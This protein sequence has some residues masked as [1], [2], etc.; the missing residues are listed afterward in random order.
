MT[1][2]L[3][4]L[5]HSS[6]FRAD[7]LFFI[8][9]TTNYIRA[10]FWDVF[11]NGTSHRKRMYDFA[12]E[13]FGESQ[14]NSPLFYG[15]TRKST[16]RADNIDPLDQQFIDFIQNLPPDLRAP[17]Q[18][19][20][21]QEHALPY[22][23]QDI[24]NHLDNLR[25]KRNYLTHY[26]TQQNKPK[27]FHDEQV[28]RFMA[29][30]LHPELY[31]QWIGRIHSHSIKLPHPQR[32]T[33]HNTML[34]LRAIAKEATEKR[35]TTTQHLYSASRS[36]KHG[37]L[38]KK[39][40]KDKV[41]SIEKWRESYLKYY[42]A[43]ARDTAPKMHY[44]KTCYHFIGKENIMQL[45]AT[46]LNA[47]PLAIERSMDHPPTRDI[48]FKRDIECLFLLGARINMLLFRHLPLD[49]AKRMDDIKDAH[50]KEHLRPLTQRIE[51]IIRQQKTCRNT[52]KHEELEIQRQQL[53]A[54]K[55]RLKSITPPEIL[56]LQQLQRIRDVIAHNGSFWHMH[57]HEGQEISLY[58]IF[59]R[60]FS[61][62]KDE[63]LDAVHDAYTGLY[64]LFTK[65]KYDRLYPKDGS[66]ALSIHRWT[67]AN[68]TTYLN[69][70][71]YTH[72]RRYNVKRVA[73]QCLRDLRQAKTDVL[74]KNT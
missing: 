44:F 6:H 58:A 72:E 7:S 3:D 32:Q 12:R 70:P 43:H 65:E 22:N 34:T 56:P 64:T 26:D 29:T 4:I 66:C 15:I 45:H 54:E 30:M 42:P 53:E 25:H 38:N 24:C 55:T 48:H 31:N 2:N 67:L 49:I 5:E 8:H 11:R 28:Q 60:V 40:R 63:N 35:S 46:I 13:H 71:N 62:L 18:A 23:L 37:K 16:Q 41:A 69:N 47:A 68:R 51:K 61:F 73:A 50:Q 19:R 52:P 20:L 57:D 33:I 1:L 14:Q 21:E 9:Q 36:K 59:L 39:E 10:V 27:Q 74:K 17:F